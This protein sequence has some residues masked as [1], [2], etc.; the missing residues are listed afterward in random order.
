MEAA[1]HSRSGPVQ[2][3]PGPRP[4][5]VLAEVAGKARPLVLASEQLLSVPGE[6]GYLLPGGGLR[7]G[8]VVAVEGATGSGR[9]SLALQLA[10]AATAAGE[11][12]AAVEL[13]P[14]GRVPR[15]GAV[16]AREA[17]VALERFA[18]VRAVEPSRWSA[19][20]AAL[21]E[22]VSLVLTEL[23]AGLRPSDARRLVARARERR[24]VLVALGGWPEGATLTVR[25]RGGSWSGLE[26]GL[27][28]TRT[29]EVEVAGRDGQR[30]PGVVAAVAA[31]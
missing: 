27:L 7:R 10:A 16:A 19:V 2:S 30:R 11:W 20:V 28:A 22:G 9:T 31:G 8:T 6:L 4:A 21:V 14:G 23:P 1:E 29:L 13:M 15:L 17:G 24:C 26:Q 12:V 25:A 5:P 18:V 3:L